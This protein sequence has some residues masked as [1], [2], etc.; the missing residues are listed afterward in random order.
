MTILDFFLKFM[1]EAGAGAEISDK[2]EPE[3]HKNRPAPHHW[4][5]LSFR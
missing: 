1:V 2:L 5:K 4:K 3:P